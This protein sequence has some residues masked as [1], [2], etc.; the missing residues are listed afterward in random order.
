[1]YSQR[2]GT[3]PV[4]H[5]TGGLKDSVTDATPANLA[6]GTAT[7]FAF[8]V[9]AEEAFLGAIDRGLALWRDLDAWRRIQRAGMARDFSWH[10]S[11]QQYLELYRSLVRA[12]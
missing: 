7:G 3:P 6:A 11:A 10:K 1:M 5:A 8:E 4:V 12:G 9:M 2:Y